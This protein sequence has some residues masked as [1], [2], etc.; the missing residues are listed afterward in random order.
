MTSPSGVSSGA[1]QDE[2]PLHHVLGLLHQIEIDVALLG[3]AVAAVAQLDGVDRLRDERVLER[4]RRP[5]RRR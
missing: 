4:R 1:R 2:A 5:R 3:D